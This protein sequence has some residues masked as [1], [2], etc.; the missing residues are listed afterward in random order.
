MK[1]PLPQPSLLWHPIRRRRFDAALTVLLGIHAFRRLNADDK[2]KVE[3]WLSAQ[4]KGFAKSEYPYFVLRQTIGESSDLIAGMRADAM[5][6]LGMPT[7]VEGL[8]WYEFLG[9]A[10][11]FRRFDPATQA[12]ANFL[13]ANG[14]TLDDDN[15]ETKDWMDLMRTRYP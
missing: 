7:G 8:K 6:R 1:V 12:A 2:A 9:S 14:I 15:A 10:Q 5:A 13:Q 4:F 3:T 11:S